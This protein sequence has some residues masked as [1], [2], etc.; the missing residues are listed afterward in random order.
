MQVSFGVIMLAL[1]HNRPKIVSL[2]EALTLF[3]EHR[4]EIV[5]R[6]TQFE[7]NKAKA[8][9]HI[10]EG[11]KIALDNLD[12]VIK[13]IRAAKDPH[14]AKDG[15]MTK[16]KLSDRQ[17]TAILEMRLQR[18]TNLERDK[19]MKDYEAILKLI[20]KLEKVLASPKLVD[21]IIIEE[22]GEIKKTF[23]DKRRTEIKATLQEFSDEDLIEEEEMVVTVTHA[24]YI[25]R[26][27]LSLYRNQKRGGKGKVGTGIK[28]EDFVTNVFVSSTHAYL[29][30]FS[31]RGKV[32]WL[33][34]HELPQVGR[35][36]RGKPI[37]NLCRMRQGEKIAAILPVKDFELG[38]YIVMATRKGIV[39]KTDLMAYSNPR[40][41]GIIACGIADGDRLISVRLTDGD[42]NIFLA[43]SQGSAIRFEEGQ[44][45]PMGR[46]ATGVTGI[47]M[48][49]DDYVVGMEVLNGKG[50]LLTATERGYGKRTDISEYRA[51]TRG[52]KGVMTIR[53]TGKNGPVVGI[54]Q[55]VDK[56]DIMLISEHGKLIRMKAKDISVIG[57]ATQGVRLIHMDTGERLV[58][59]AKI[60]S[61]DEE[62]K[63]H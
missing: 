13:L 38:K 25:K 35:A 57:R 3:I 32:Y 15:L 48:S 61:E 9:A 12:A 39:K 1:V 33:R 43:T 4:R 31:D 37:I 21:K 14:A 34:V 50:T 24:G 42:S 40:A 53:V 2:R 51:Q 54:T 60:A 52:G 41:S 16:F 18:L 19:I 45:R 6:R 46:V 29:L 22:L 23:G 30:V 62:E 36:A 49:K 17:S 5:T 55:I 7:L 20:A 63:T 59:I 56:D 8:Q 10:L 11:L 28:E 44:V 58:S 27:P 47:R 26:N